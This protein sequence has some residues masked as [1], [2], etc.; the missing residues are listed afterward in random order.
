MP[1]NLLKRIFTHPL[2][3]HL[4]LDAP[5]NTRQRAHLIQDK[6]F[7]KQFYLD[8]YHAI[9]NLLPPGIKGPVVELGSGGGFCKDVIADL[10]TSDV[11][12]IPIVDLIF[13]GHSMP[14]KTASLR[15]IV[16]MDVFHHIPRPDTFL[17]QAADVIKSGGHIIMIEPWVTAWSRFVYRYLHHEP[18]ND[19]VK[20]WHIKNGGPLSGAN[21]A[22]PWIVFDRDRKKFE[23]RFPEWQINQIILHTPFCYLLSGGVS[24]KSFLPGICYKFCRKLENRMQPL[25]A[26]V[27]MFATIVLRRQISSSY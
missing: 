26:F 21:S 20:D 10:I 7:L 4:D 18:F 22:I 6:S 8:N 2:A 19:E 24:Y 23:C 1:K 13:N 11:L 17:A 5:E 27:A 15:A 14:F 25:N 12:R 9:A 3:R 16:M